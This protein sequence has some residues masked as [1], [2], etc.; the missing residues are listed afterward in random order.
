MKQWRKIRPIFSSENSIFK[1]PVCFNIV[2]AVRD[3][4]GGRIK[5]ARKE[6][7]GLCERARPR[8]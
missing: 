7:C 8:S 4:A 2:R 3:K 5:M 1:G 6:A